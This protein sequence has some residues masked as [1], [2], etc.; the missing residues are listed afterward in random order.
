MIERLYANSHILNDGGQH[1]DY[2][3]V[4]GSLTTDNEDGANHCSLNILHSLQHLGYVIP[5]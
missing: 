3:R 5:L 2:G 1:T 4:G